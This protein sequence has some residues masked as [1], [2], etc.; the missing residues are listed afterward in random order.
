[1]NDYSLNDFYR[2]LIGEN[3][4][5]FL[6]EVAYRSLI[7]FLVLIFFLNLF[8]KRLTKEL[9]LT[10]MAIFI[11]L[12]AIISEPLQLPETGI[13]Q[14][15]VCLI[16]ALLFIRGLNYFSLKNQQ[17]EKI[18]HGEVQILV[19]DGVIQVETLHKNRISQHQLFAIL[20]A[21]DIF[22]LGEV[23]RLY[24]EASGLNNIYRI[25]SDVIGLSIYPESPP[26]EIA[27]S[28]KSACTLCGMIKEQKINC[29][30][31]GNDEF[32]LAI[33]STHQ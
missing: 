5:E 6:F 13:L 32:T 18:T 11:T 22:N 19:K 1:M 9:S 7:V 20:R 33:L 24:L 3:P 26:L 15:I 2:I 25:K 21:K 28:D 8:G 16:C 23:K 10:E 17:F 30:N 31:C 29:N 27:F 14:G 12:G 4:I